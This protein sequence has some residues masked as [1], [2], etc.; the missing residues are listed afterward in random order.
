VLPPKVS[1]LTAEDFL[2]LLP[3]IPVNKLANDIALLGA[4]ALP[5]ALRAT[6]VGGG[7]GAG[8]GGG[9]GGGGGSF[10]DDPIISY[11]M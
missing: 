7:G 9:G 2:L 3:N 6:G 1:F 10:G 8:G 11:S 4:F 5:I